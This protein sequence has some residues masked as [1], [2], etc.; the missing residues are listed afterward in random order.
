MQSETGIAATYHTEAVKQGKPKDDGEGDKKQQKDLSKIKCYGCRKKGHMK[1][2]PLCPKNIEKVKKEKQEAGGGE[3]AFMN[4]TWCKECEG[5][6]YTTVRFEDEEIKEYVVGMAVNAMRGITLTQVLLNN[7]ADIS[8][9]HPML[10][11]YV[12]PAEKKIRVCG[13]RGIQLIVE[14]VGM[15]DGFFEVYAS[16]KTKVNVLSICG[17]RRQV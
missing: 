14:H 12:R 2:S 11:R 5:S 15:L 3:D 16:E 1:N 17:G 4:A 9:M 6:M 13:V 8:V 10:L 7:Q